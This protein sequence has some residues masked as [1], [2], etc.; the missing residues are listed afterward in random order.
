MNKNHKEIIQ[1]KTLES[2][3][4]VFLQE[5]L[6]GEIEKDLPIEVNIS[7]ITEIISILN[8]RTGK[9]KI[10]VAAAYTEFISEFLGYEMLYPAGVA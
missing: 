7:L 6:N 3:S 2:M 5:L 4:T 9:S 10:N 1:G 8:S